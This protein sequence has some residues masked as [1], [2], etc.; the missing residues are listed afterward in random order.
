M[1]RCNKK[2]H[3]RNNEL[4]HVRSPGIELSR[5]DKLFST[6]VKRKRI[7]PPNYRCFQLSEPTN[8]LYHKRGAKSIPK[9]VLHASPLPPLC[10]IL[11]LVIETERGDR[12]A[13]DR[14]Q[15]R[16]RDYSLRLNVALP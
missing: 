4:S 16:D 1:A 12:D 6:F 15:K 11:Q 8:I 10:L 7:G 2:P 14:D 13:A 5:Q 3:G 9:L